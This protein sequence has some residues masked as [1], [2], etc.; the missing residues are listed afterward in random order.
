MK[1]V[2]IIMA[3]ACFSISFVILNYCNKTRRKKGPLLSQS[4]LSLSEEERKYFDTD[5]EY[6]RITIVYGLIGIFFVFV[7]IIIL[8]LSKIFAF[9]AMAVLLAD[10]IYM[11]IKLFQVKK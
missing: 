7:G 11:G 1:P 10:L 5:S 2:Q 3:I 9:A 6:K 8:T 4:Y